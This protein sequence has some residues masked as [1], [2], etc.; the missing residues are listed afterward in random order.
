MSTTTTV[1]DVD[2]ARLERQ[3][4]F[5]LAM[6][7]RTGRITDAVALAAVA[8]TH[9]PPRNIRGLR[10]ERDSPHKVFCSCRSEPVAHTACGTE[11]RRC[12]GKPRD[13]SPGPAVADSKRP[14]EP[15]SGVR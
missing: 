4:R 8:P 5:A 10:A 11:L 1:P 9:P 14:S 7:S 6:A 2:P 15:R 12:V 13:H 3:V